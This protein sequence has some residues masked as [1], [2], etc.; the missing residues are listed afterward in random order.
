[1]RKKKK[2]KEKKDEG[3]GEREDKGMAELGREDGAG[4][5]W[6]NGWKI[7]KSVG[8]GRRKKIK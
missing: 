1:M 6:S 2:K 7:P 8:G 4:G 5:K 3:G